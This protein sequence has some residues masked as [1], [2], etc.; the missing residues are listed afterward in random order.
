MT[1]FEHSLSFSSFSESCKASEP[2]EWLLAGL[3]STPP[4]AIERSVDPITAAA[5]H[6]WAI[7]MS[8]CSVA[9]T[10]G[11]IHRRKSITP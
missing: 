6:F 11:Y 1:V 7:E 4:S 2:S 8:R 3:F 5:L 10:T 9:Y